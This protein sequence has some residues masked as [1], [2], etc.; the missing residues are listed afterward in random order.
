MTHVDV[1]ECAINVGNKYKNVTV[2]RQL[3][4]EQVCFYFK[5]LMNMYWVVYLQYEHYTKHITLQTKSF[6][7]TP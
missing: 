7:I 3:C 5:I 1:D 4:S 6:K 2:D